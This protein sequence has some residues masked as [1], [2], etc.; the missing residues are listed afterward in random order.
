MYRSVWR[1]YLSGIQ[2]AAPLGRGRG[3]LGRRRGT[4]PGRVPDRRKRGTA[5]TGRQVFRFRGPVW[6]SNTTSI[7][8]QNRG[9]PA[10]T[11]DPALRDSAIWTPIYSAPLG[12]RI[13]VGTIW[14]FSFQEKGNRKNLKI[15]QKRS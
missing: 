2:G 14:L 13:T 5:D 15:Y 10:V 8:K 9:E 4:L 3:M 11:A 12:F 6:K 1:R 7:L